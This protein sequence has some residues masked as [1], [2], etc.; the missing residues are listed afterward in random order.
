LNGGKKENRT[1]RVNAPGGSGGSGGNPGNTGESSLTEA[2]KKKYASIPNASINA[3]V[4]N[5]ESVSIYVRACWDTWF[6]LLVNGWQGKSAA[7]ET[8]ETVPGK[9]KKKA[10]TRTVNRSHS[11]VLGTPGIGKSTFVLYMIFRVLLTDATKSATFILEGEENLRPWRKK[12]V[13]KNGV[14]VTAL[15]GDGSSFKNEITQPDVFYF[16]DGIS[17]AKPPVT[18]RP[19]T[20]EVTSP[21]QDRWHAFSKQSDQ[22]EDIITRCM[23]GWSLAELRAAR[24]ALGNTMT[25]EELEARHAVLGGTFRFVLTDPRV[26]PLDKVESTLVKTELKKM[27]DSNGA[28]GCEQGVSNVLVHLYP[29]LTDAERMH[30]NVKYEFASKTVAQL[31]RE[32]TKLQHKDFFK[33]IVNFSGENI[34]FSGLKGR[35]FEDEAHERLMQ[36][37]TFEVQQLQPPKGKGKKR[38]KPGDVEKL[39]IPPFKQ[40]PQSL[41][42]AQDIKN[43]SST[44]YFKPS[45]PHFASV[46][47]VAQP[48]LMFQMLTGLRHPLG[49]AKLQQL[50]LHLK[51]SDKARLY[52]VGPR[53][54]LGS[55]YFQPYT[56]NGKVIGTD[57]LPADIANIEQWF[58]A[59]DLGDTDG[60]T[61]MSD[62][63][64][65]SSSSSSA[66]KAKKAKIVKSSTKKGK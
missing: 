10:K 36:G 54:M 50:L 37:G 58:L 53:A 45:S 15:E 17:P 25:D 65:S 9:T 4:L 23:E 33:T 19:C 16:L 62:D 63:D 2:D 18:K 27:V 44:V 11:I 24:D 29:D 64:S 14:L 26:K 47:A 30:D 52:L 40:P 13:Y 60:D 32:R 46:D 21:K 66:P 42:S 39:K 59:I 1:L 8:Q 34:Y 12:L 6:N 56:L 28:I 48:S 61:D 7:G 35:L 38:P 31:V 51:H 55:V 41:Q 5:L 49:I 57:E 3:G 20:L 43:A 22:H